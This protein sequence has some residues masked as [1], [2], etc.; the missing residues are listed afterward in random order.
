MSLVIE[1]SGR[2]I[3]PCVSFMLVRDDTLLLETRSMLKAS[4]PGLIA[5]PGGHMEEGETEAATLARELDEEL[6]VVALQSWHLCSLYHPAT[7]ELQLIHYYVVPAW[8]GDIVAGEADRVD[9]HALQED[10]PI[11][12]A[13]DRV[14][15]AELRRLWG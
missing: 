6:G 7:D 2:R 10:M 9:F 4:D 15:V 11:D 13:A 14:A 3:W 5:I 1:Q 12:V 8:R